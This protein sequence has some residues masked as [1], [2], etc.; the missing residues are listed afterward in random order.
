[1][2][3]VIWDFFAKRS[4]LLNGKL[5]AK[6]NACG[7]PISRG[8]DMPGRCTTVSLVAHLRGK[9]FEKEF[10][11]YEAKAAKLANK[12]ESGDS[13]APVLDQPTLPQMLERRKPLPTDSP[14]A[15]EL[16]SALTEMIAIDMQPFHIVH[17]K[18]SRRL[19]QK[20]APRYEIPSGKH[21]RRTSLP[22]LFAKV[23][24]KL[25]SAL[26]GVVKVSLTTDGW[27]AKH[28]PQSFIG[29]TI[30]WID[31]HFKRHEATLAARYFPGIFLI[32]QPN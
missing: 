31:G 18:G 27:T 20:A 9:H 15:I 10:K 7:M 24:S 28:S 21:F 5:V 14:Q 2:T 19:M 23:K 26:E 13:S 16:T 4:E 3:S 11:A 12:S 22:D 32:F 8:S 6:C 1:M 17:R 25:K 29:V 30:H